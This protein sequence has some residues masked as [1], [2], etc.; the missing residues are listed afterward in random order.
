ML[1]FTLAGT[2][3]YTEK[4]I[5]LSIF[6]CSVSF[7]LRLCQSMWMSRREQF[8]NGETVENFIWSQNLS[9]TTYKCT[10][11]FS[12]WLVFLWKRWSNSQLQTLQH[13][14]CVNFVLV[15]L[16]GG[17]EESSSQM[18]SL[19]QT[20]I[21]SQNNS[22]TTDTC[23]YVLSDICFFAK[24][25]LFQK[26]KG[27]KKCALQAQLDYEDNLSRFRRFQLVKWLH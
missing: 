27:F 24:G 6:S 2:S 25:S 19:F 10:F 20:F 8:S 22:L 23:F 1:N 4:P 18:V 17:Q 12:V 11:Y 15:I 7:Q 9:F 13:M 26:C 16:W 5:A 14:F 21:W 3:F